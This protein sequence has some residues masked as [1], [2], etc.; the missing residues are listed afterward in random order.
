MDNFTRCPLACVHPFSGSITGST[1]PSL[2]LPGSL[3]WVFCLIGMHPWVS[4]CLFCSEEVLARG[5]VGGSAFIPERSCCIRSHFHHLNSPSNLSPSCRKSKPVCLLMMS[6]VIKCDL[7]SAFR[8]KRARSPP[9]LHP[10]PHFHSPC[11]GQRMTVFRRLSTS[12][13]PPFVGYRGSGGA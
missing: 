11:L 12:V 4:N 7:T 6:G 8:Q 1:E 9:P 13:H 3:S 2:R 10:S 5:D